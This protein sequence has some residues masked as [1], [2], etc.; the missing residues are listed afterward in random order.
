MCRQHFSIGP[1]RF[2]TNTTAN[3]LW[4]QHILDNITYCSYLACKNNTLAITIVGREIPHP[5]TTRLL[6]LLLNN[7]T[8]DL[9]HLYTKRFVRESRSTLKLNELVFCNKIRYTEKNQGWLYVIKGTTPNFKKF[10]KSVRIIGI[11]IAILACID[12]KLHKY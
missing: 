1:L 6:F 3:R 7:R 5:S 8:F 4:L 10:N 9:N 2:R 11:P 12:L